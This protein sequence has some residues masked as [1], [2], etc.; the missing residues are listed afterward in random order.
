MSHFKRN[1]LIGAIVLVNSVGLNATTINSEWS[2][3]LELDMLQSEL[4]LTD[5]VVEGSPQYN[6]NNNISMQNIES[7]Y[8]KTFTSVDEVMCFI[9]Y[10][11]G[12]L[13][14]VFYNNYNYVEVS[15]N[16][17]K[18]VNLIEKNRCLVFYKNKATI[19][20]GLENRL[21]VFK[22]GTYTT[23]MV[24]SFKDG[25]TVQDILYMGYS[26]GNTYVIV[27]LTGIDTSN[28]KF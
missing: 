15:L 3:N 2:K 6:F 14:E 13:A 22:D 24:N 17:I 12:E 20:G 26:V 27:Y 9:P 23:D 8:L 4:Q 5:Q 7:S 18:S 25:K 11:T 1:M 28:F 10:L 19:S 21:I 16:V